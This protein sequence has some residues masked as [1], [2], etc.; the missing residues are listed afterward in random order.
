V[1][2]AATP[3][4]T[5]VAADP[6]RDVERAIHTWAKAWADRNV[7]QYIAVYERSY[8]PP[9]QSHGAWEQ[10]RRSRIL[11]K[12]HIAVSIQDLQIQVSGSKAVAKFRQGYRADTL[13]VQ[14]RKTLELIRQGDRW[15]I[16]KES[17]G[18]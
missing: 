4:R 7:P 11:S 14:S 9:G 10:E 12:S 16:A 15:L 17:T 3:A 5:P 8:S 1:A 2:A 18:N 13:S 6:S